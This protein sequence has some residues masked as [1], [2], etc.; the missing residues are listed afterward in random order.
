MI[1]NSIQNLKILVAHIMILFEE[2]KFSK[3]EGNNGFFIKRDPDDISKK[4]NVI[5]QD[6]RMRR[7]LGNARKTAEEYSWSKVADR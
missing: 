3:K 7:E 2:R 6:D 5:L 1:N 4:L